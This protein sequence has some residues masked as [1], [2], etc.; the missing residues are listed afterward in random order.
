MPKTRLELNALNVTALK[1]LCSQDK[2]KYRGYSKLSML[3]HAPTSV[4]VQCTQVQFH[5]V[6]DKTN[7]IEHILQSQEAAGA[8]DD[9]RTRMMLEMIQMWFLT[10][11]NRFDLSCVL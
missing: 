1:A 9:I 11:L 8:D 6:I 4:G 10:P 5:A 3:F 2:Q 7:L